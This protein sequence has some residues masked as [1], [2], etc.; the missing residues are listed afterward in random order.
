MSVGQQER[1]IQ[2][3]RKALDQRGVKAT[4]V[5]SEDNDERSTWKSV[6]S[7]DRKTL[8][9]IS[10]I[11]THTYGANAPDQLRTFAEHSGKPLWVS[12]YGDG[13]HSGMQLAR[14]IRDDIVEMHAQVWIY[15]QFADNNSSWGMVFN[16][17]DGRDT[18]YR[19]T[20]KFYVMAQFSRFIRPGSEIIQTTDNDTLAAYDPARQQLVIVSVND[21]S[22]SRTVTYQLN[23]LESYE[24]EVFSYQTSPNENMA[25]QPRI[26]AAKGRFTI[27]RTPQSVATFIIS[28]AKRE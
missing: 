13:D 8:D 1:L 7:Y 20:R 24:H 21:N 4:I 3:L 26:M 27:D 28:N 16:R 15:W 25:A 12:E 22:V 23:G 14:R 10:H 11:A 18:S 17:L 2:L 6:S 9:D 5:A 19:L